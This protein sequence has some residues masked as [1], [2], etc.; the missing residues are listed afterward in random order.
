MPPDPKSFIGKQC[1]LD[2]Q[3]KRYR[4]VVTDCAYIGLNP[5]GNIPDYRITVRGPNRTVTL[6][7][8]VDAY[9][10]VDE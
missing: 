5:R 8:M 3:G 10:F 7:S 6:P 4:A 9:C 2:Y 1:S